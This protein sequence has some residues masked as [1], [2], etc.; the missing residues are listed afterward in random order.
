VCTKQI[1]QWPGLKKGNIQIEKPLTILI[2]AIENA[3]PLEVYKLEKNASVWLT[4][5]G[6]STND[7]HF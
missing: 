2:Q 7:R 6:S 5:A 1:H 3:V 4:V